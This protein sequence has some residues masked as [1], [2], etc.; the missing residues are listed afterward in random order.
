MTTQCAIGAVAGQRGWLPRRAVPA[1]RL[2]VA[3]RG[4][5]LDNGS[6]TAQVRELCAE[7][8]FSVRLLGQSRQPVSADERHL[9]GMS[10]GQWALVREVYLC[11]GSQP[12]VFARS[13]VPPHGLEGA[14]RHLRRQGQRPL[15]ATLFADVR[16]RR[17]PLEIG[18]L[19]PS[20]ALCRRL[21]DEALLSAGRPLWGRR[22]VFFLRRQPL[23]VSEFFLPAFVRALD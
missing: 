11:R 3:L 19:P 1:A 20:D 8:P 7:Q 22:S 12:L 21:Q 9:L 14:W 23:L 16:V 4:V 15:G 17:G 13:L 5:L 18:C 6:L 10:P 2:P